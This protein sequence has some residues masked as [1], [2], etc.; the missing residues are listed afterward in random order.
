MWSAAVGSISAVI[1]NVCG[2][3]VVK[4]NKTEAEQKTAGA[5]GKK[6]AKHAGNLGLLYAVGA[7]GGTGNQPY[8][9]E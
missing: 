3:G 4:Q 8:T 7:A 2:G 6:R 5:D 9:T 1:V